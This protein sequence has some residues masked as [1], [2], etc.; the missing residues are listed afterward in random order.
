ME[1]PQSL[2]ARVE[3][4]SYPRKAFPLALST[5]LEIETFQFKRIINGE[6]MGCQGYKG[7]CAEKSMYPTASAG[8]SFEAR[9]WY[10]KG[11]LYRDKKRRAERSCY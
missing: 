5:I 7:G 8:S 1:T 2:L 4:A 10:A 3:K 9:A 11:R 6:G